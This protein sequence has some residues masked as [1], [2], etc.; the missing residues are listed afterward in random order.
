MS[1]EILHFAR[2]ADE[3]WAAYQALNDEALA[4][5]RMMFDPDHIERRAAAH[6][7]FA[8]LFRRECQHSAQT[9]FRLI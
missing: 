9:R 1:A 8:A 7:V 6:D 3:A 2:S 5:S 4:D